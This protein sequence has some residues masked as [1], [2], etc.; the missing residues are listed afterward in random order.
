M[1]LSP[2]SAIEVVRKEAS[3]PYEVHGRPEWIPKTGTL[4]KATKLIF[5]DKPKGQM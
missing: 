2:N 4:I 5:F 3:H 1:A